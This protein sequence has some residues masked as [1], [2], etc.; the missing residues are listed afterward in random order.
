MKTVDFKKSTVYQIYPKS[1]YDSNHD[2]LGDLRGVIQKLD[3]IKEL[4]AD[5]I[6]LTP[7]FVSPQN[8]NG[9]DVE[10]YYNIDPRYGTMEDVEELIR[11]ADKRGIRLMFD[12]VFNHVSNRHEWFKKAMEGDPYYKDFF[13]FKKA[14]KTESLRLT[15]RVSLAE[16]PGSMWKNSMNIICIF[17]MSPSRILTGTMEM[18]AKKCRTSCASGW[19]RES[20]ASDLTW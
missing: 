17:M 6:W 10:D 8:D 16:V 4:G 3:Y 11:E 5:Y 15:G 20:K 19:E 7:F 12:M 14:R 13:F 18:S 9:Y 1:F 2:G